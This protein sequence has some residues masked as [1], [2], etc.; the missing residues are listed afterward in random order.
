MTHTTQWWNFIISIQS[1]TILHI[2]PTL[3][4]Q[5]ETNEKTPPKTKPIIPPLILHSQAP[6]K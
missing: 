4:T 3:S 5:S 1:E 2:L 6:S